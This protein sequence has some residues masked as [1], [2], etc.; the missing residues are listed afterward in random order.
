[1]SC[2]LRSR[3]PHLKS[4]NLSPSHPPLELDNPEANAVVIVL[5]GLGANG[6]D[7]LPL[8]Q[9]LQ[10]VQRDIRVLLPQAPHRNV[11][12][13]N[14]MKMPAWYDIVSADFSNEKQ[15]AGLEES[16]QYVTGLITEQAQRGI[17]A[18]RI[19]LTGFSQGGAVAL[20]TALR[21]PHEI[22]GVAALSA[23]LPPGEYANASA[24]AIFMAHGIYDE[25]VPMAAAAASRARLNAMGYAVSWHEYAIGHQLSIELTADLNAWL[26]QILQTTGA[27]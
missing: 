8:G 23:Y 1:M 6:E 15:P 24:P 12:I 20:Y 27:G 14:G 17:A 9:A 7:L 4:A 19:V 11:T 21:S 13:N 10:A 22:A 5:H 18:N 26:G 16:Y 2:Q 3:R 25:V